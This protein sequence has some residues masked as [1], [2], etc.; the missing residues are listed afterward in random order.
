[1]TKKKYNVFLKINLIFKTIIKKKF[2][3]NV[4]FF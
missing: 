1:M 3:K 4:L 2:N